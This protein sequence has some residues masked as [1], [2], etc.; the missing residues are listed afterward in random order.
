MQLTSNPVLTTTHQAG[1]SLQT[2]NRFV[3]LSSGKIVYCGA[4]QKAIGVIDL[5]WNDNDIA[6]V[7]QLGV[8]LVEVGAGGVTEGAEVVSDANGKAV[9]GTALSATVPGTGTPVTSSSAQPSLTIAGGV[10][11]QKVLGT[12][13]DT[14]AENGLTRILL[15]I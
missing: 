15:R 9:L 12:T 10:L 14:I 2:K 4:G 6:S 8:V 13:L 1:A 5:P 7:I 11:P 3:K